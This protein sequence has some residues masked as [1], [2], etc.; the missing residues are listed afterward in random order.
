MKLRSTAARSL[1]PIPLSVLVTLLWVG[2]VRLLFLL[3]AA[4][5]R[6]EHD[7]EG[8]AAMLFGVQVLG[9]ARLPTIM[10]R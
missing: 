3:A 2:L 6:W 8:W 5:A 1:L 7:G 4:Q 9:R 10:R